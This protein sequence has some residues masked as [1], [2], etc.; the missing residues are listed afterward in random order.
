MLKIQK[1]A[2]E[3]F[4]F[5]FSFSFVYNLLYTTDL[6]EHNTNPKVGR[7]VMEYVSMFFV[8]ILFFKQ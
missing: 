4:V 2:F 5:F 8:L 7:V 1:N 6:P 3:D